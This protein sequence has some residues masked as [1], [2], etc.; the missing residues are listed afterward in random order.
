MVASGRDLHLMN[1]LGEL[2]VELENLTLEF[3]R[4]VFYKLTVTG[5]DMPEDQ[6]VVDTA[7]PE[8]F[9]ELAV[10]AMSKIAYKRSVHQAAAASL[11]PVV[12]GEALQAFDELPRIMPRHVAIE[13]A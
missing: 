9:G 1:Q 13:P 6:N 3:P 4:T 7:L 10:I 8:M 12:V 2:A 5:V 11:L